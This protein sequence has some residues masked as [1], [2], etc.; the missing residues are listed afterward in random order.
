MYGLLSVQ[1]SLTTV[2]AGAC[3]ATPAVGEL[4]RANP[5]LLLVAF[6]LSMAL[7]VALHVKSRET[8]TNLVLLAAFVSPLY[9]NLNEC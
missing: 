1:L 9:L 5:W 7:L 8:P 6:V 4:V 3:M 2:V